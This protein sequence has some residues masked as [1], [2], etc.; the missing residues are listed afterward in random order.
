L[1]RA[2]GVPAGPVNDVAAALAEP[3]VV[4]R[5]MVMTLENGTGDAVRVPGDPL[6]LRTSGRQ[7]YEFPPGLGDHG[8]RVLEDLLGYST[9]DIDALE[10]SGVLG[11]AARPAP[12]QR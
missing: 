6:K 7:H 2:A 12:V 9:A 1:L 3:Q 8:R 4:H 5:G 10:A 11:R